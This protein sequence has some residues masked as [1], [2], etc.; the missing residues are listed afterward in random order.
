MVIVKEEQKALINIEENLTEKQHFLEIQKL[1]YDEK[2]V[3][4]EHLITK[5][6]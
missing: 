5:V 6:I 4:K 1:E 3:I 2:N